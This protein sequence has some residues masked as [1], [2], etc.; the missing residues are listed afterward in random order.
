[1]K[2]VLLGDTSVGKRCLV[3]RVVHAAAR[4]DAA[5]PIPARRHLYISHAPVS[6]STS[7]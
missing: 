1:M 2:L 7:I 6:S 5:A 3:V 4:L